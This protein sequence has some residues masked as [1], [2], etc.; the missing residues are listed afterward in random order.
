MG[1]TPRLVMLVSLMMAAMLAVFMIFGGAIETRTG[2]FFATQPSSLTVALVVLAGLS[3]DVVLPLPSSLFSAVAVGWLGPVTGT[4]VIWAG[5]TAGHILA[6]A[7]GRR[8][9]PAAVGRWAGGADAQAQLDRMCAG[10]KLTTVLAMTRAVP[11][12]SETTAIVAGAGRMPVGRF[13]LTCGL[14]NLGVALVYGVFSAVLS[15]EN[16]FYTVFAASLVVPALGYGL[17][18]CVAGRRFL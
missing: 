6:Y 4:A 5:M 16:A 7:L 3:A 10:L 9:G 2:D 17:L 8:F 11:I 15:G 18:W 14:A 13:V 12:L 1:N